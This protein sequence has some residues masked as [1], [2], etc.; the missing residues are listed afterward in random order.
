MKSRYKIHD[1][2]NSQF[3]FITSTIIEW[4]P[5]FTCQEHFDIIIRNL[6]FYRKQNQIK[7]Y[8]YVI[9][10]NHLHLIVSG[11]D[12]P[13]TIRSLKSYTA[14]QLL[15]SIQEKQMVWLLNQLEYYKA[16]HK[17]SSQYQVWQEGYHPQQI[18]SEATL[19]QKVEYIHYNPVR[20]GYVKRPEH[21]RYSSAEEI[22][23]K[24]DGELKVDLMH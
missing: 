20:R 8:A 1:P 10:E 2:S 12:L 7:I 21:W 4:L 18:T 13:G 16:R 23:M 11:P 14:K 6:A 17:K 3:H 19:R 15:D 24:T 22:L 9:M 5:V